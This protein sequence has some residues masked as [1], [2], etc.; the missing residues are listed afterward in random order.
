M[1][2]RASGQSNQELVRNLIRLDLLHPDQAPLVARG[3]LEVDRAWFVPSSFAAAA[4][5][6][7]PFHN[8]VFHL[9]APHLYAQV[10]EALDLRPGLSFLNLGS[11]TGYL[12]Y[13]VAS[14]VGPQGRCDGVEQHAALVEFASG[15]AS[16]IPQLR[17]L[18][19]CSFV[20]GNAFR[21]DVDSGEGYD[22]IYIGGGVSADFVDAF[23]VLLHVRGFMV[24]P[25]DNELVRIERLSEDVFRMTVI[26]AVR[27]APFAQ[28]DFDLLPLLER[29]DCH[30]PE[31]CLCVSYSTQR[32]TPEPRGRGLAISE[33]DALRDSSETYHSEDGI[34]R[35]NV[36]L[37]DL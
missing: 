17:A 22:R 2:Y 15:R 27:F 14:I 19:F 26:A 9:S 36:I 4:Y 29:L 8:G 24:A 5:R 7:E 30:N 18:G 23:R 37:N 3:L 21:V 11:G 25:R 1:A 34:S 6:D 33:T 10:L 35:A 12:S 13:V 20:A 16:E 28:L 32:V 31:S